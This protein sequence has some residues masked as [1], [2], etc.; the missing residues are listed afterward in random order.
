MPRRKAARP[1]FAYTFTTIKRRMRRGDSRKTLTAFVK[2]C[3]AGAVYWNRRY[4]PRGAE[5]DKAPQAALEAQG[6]TP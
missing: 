5:T 4:A 1:S 3:G 2:E 6:L